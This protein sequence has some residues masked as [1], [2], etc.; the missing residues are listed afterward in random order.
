M[1]FI[2]RF[3]FMAAF[4]AAIVSLPAAAF[5]P[6]YVRMPEPMN[7]PALAAAPDELDR[8]RAA[9][10]SEG[11][12]RDALKAVV[13]W[14]D[15][16]MAKP[17][18]FPPRGGQ[19]NQWYQCN[20]C[21]IGLATIDDTHHKCP[22]CGKVYTGSPYDDVIFGRR[23]TAIFSGM[24]Y[25]AWAYAITGDEK[26]AAHVRAALLG[27]AAR[28]NQYPRHDANLKEPPGYGGAHIFEQTLNETQIMAGTIAPAYDLVYSSKS[29]RPADRRKIESGLIRPLLANAARN[30]RG[31]SNWQSYHNAAFLA[32][33]IVLHDP[34][35]IDRALNDP[36]NG[37]LFQM[38][39]SITPDGMWYENSWSY[40]FYT[41]TALTE[42][43]EYARRFGIDLWSRPL[44]RKM[45]TIPA[46]YRMPDGSLPRLGDATDPMADA[47]ARDNEAAW[48]ATRDPGLAQLLA[49]KP[50]LESIL[51]GRDTTTT[52]S[53]TTQ[54][55]SELLPGAGHAILR[56]P[57][58]AG[59]A[60][61]LSFGE[62]GGSHGHLDKNSFVLFG[63]N[64]EIGVDPGRARSQAYR[65][66][67]HKNWYKSTLSHNTVMVDK[68]P[69]KPAAGKSLFFQA[70]DEFSIAAAENGGSYPGVEHFRTLVQAP[71]YLLVIDQLESAVR[72]R[73]DFL[74]HNIGTA[75][76]CTAAL[77]PGEARDFTGME[78]VKNQRVG[79][80][81]G[82][83][84]VTF[85]GKNIDTFLTLDAQ[86]GT[87]ILIGDGPAGSVDT[88][89]P[90]AIFTREGSS[91]SFA[92]AIEPVPTGGKRRVISVAMKEESGAL[93]VTV[94][95][96]NG[97]D[98]VTIDRNHRV[99][100]KRD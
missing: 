92:A 41:L 82:A 3:S 68:T 99:A 24:R 52:T 79:S 69:Q 2:L 36:K 85:T 76:D 90:M 14:A 59:L 20:A 27:Y 22:K 89:V 97:R 39:N 18:D 16:A 53:A 5:T 25:A 17:L 86:P 63:H 96:E 61:V 37:F 34:A 57:K 51:Y 75:A 60:S 67:I 28:Y 94:T 95:R 73:Y 64:S 47:A 29:M 33:G 50:S 80:S 11:P 93:V 71:E 54:P 91:A 35:W 8:L 43:A 44:L 26:Y 23:H 30:K 56:G 58:P 72:H 84:V 70:G 10:K 12:D 42:T 6:V 46:I 9:W 31:I 78:Y 13:R 1:M 81:D 4:V 100:V 65:L 19:H 55:A 62:Y 88:R 21:Q 83:V 15:K 49:D 32:G 87:G 48:H 74:Y 66:P 77:E 7:H 40:H 98:T 45:Y 38:E